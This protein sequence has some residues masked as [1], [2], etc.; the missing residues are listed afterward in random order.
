MEFNRKSS[1][2]AFSVTGTNHQ[3]DW[4]SLAWHYQNK[5]GKVKRF[6]LTL[7]RGWIILL[8]GF[9]EGKPFFTF[10]W[11]FYL[12]SQQER[13]VKGTRASPELLSLHY[14]AVSG[15]NTG[16]I[17]SSFHLIMSVSVFL[18]FSL[19]FLVLEFSQ[20]RRDQRWCCRPRNPWFK[21]VSDSFLKTLHKSQLFPQE[22]NFPATICVVSHPLAAAKFS[23][24]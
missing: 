19:N 22:V 1:E 12:I 20:A 11:G 3:E 21:T 23:N 7:I 9:S 13:P 6:V 4:N 14:S 18:V 10:L 17:A 16:I 2:A 15:S 24:Y 8:N 5:L